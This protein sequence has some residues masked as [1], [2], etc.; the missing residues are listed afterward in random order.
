ME[1]ECIIGL[2]NDYPEQFL[3]TLNGLKQY[4]KEEHN[5]YK[6]HKNWFK[7]PPYTLKDY[8]EGVDDLDRFNYCPYCGK[9]IDWKAIKKEND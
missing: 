7:T 9:E 4:I 6:R 5:T 8:C 2:F 1:H 3:T